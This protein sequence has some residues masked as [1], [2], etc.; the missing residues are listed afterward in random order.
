MEQ[1][2]AGID[3]S[4]PVP[5]PSAAMQSQPLPSLARSQL[6]QTERVWQSHTF[7]IEGGTHIRETNTYVRAVRGRG[8]YSSLDVWA[9]FDPLGVGN[10]QEANGQ[11]KCEFVPVRFEMTRAY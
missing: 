9:I 7:C 6:E 4:P 2:G 3:R 8:I 11:S 1:I 10:I 5:L